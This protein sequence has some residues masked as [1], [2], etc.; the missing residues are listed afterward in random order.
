MGDV[1]DALL[2]EP[3]EE[4]GPRLEQRSQGERREDGGRLEL[5]GRRI[6]GLALAELSRG[7]TGDEAITDGMAWIGS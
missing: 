2:R 6:H 1:R 4:R 5:D 3:L 7:V